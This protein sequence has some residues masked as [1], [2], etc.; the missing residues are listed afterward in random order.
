MGSR[1]SSYGFTLIEL[2][3]VI[4]ILGLFGSFALPKL[5]S[6]LGINLR[7]SAT[8]LAGYFQAGYEQAVMRRQRIRIRFD[9][10]RN[11]YWAEEYQEPQTIPLLDHTTKL[12]DA[13]EAFEKRAEEDPLLPEEQ[14][15]AEQKNYARVEAGSLKPAKLSSG[16]KFETVRLPITRN[17]DETIEP[18][19]DFLPSG[20]ATKAVVYI[21]NDSGDFY[22]VI[23]PAL[24]GRSRIE[25][26]KVELDDV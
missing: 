22:S 25:K 17:E 16:V 9:L 24:G 14:A 1:S 21:T 23:V 19:I 18:W 20:F 13:I 11:L 8:R 12:D 10:S 3:F 6:V 7:T 26:G 15:T 5:S 4:L 2:V